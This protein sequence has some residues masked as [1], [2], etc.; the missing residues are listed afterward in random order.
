M[1]VISYT[2]LVIKENGKQIQKGMNFGIQKTYSV[3]LMSTQKNAPYNDH[4]L[5]E[6]VI[7]YEGHDVPS[8]LNPDKKLVDQS[9]LTPSGTPTENG[10][11]FQAALDYKEGI[12]EPSQVQVYR[13]LRKG[14][15]VDMG[16]YDLIDAYEK[17][18][19]ERKVFKFLLK[20]KIEL[21]EN[22]QE[23]LDLL[24]DRQIPGEVQKE[25][26]ERDR[27]KCVKCG[28]TENLH[29]D[30]ILPFSKGGS[31]KVAKNI[32]LLCARHNLKKGAKFV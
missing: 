19:L 7:E 4:I 2:Q 6:G 18:D 29:F 28:S 12:K 26:Y 25:V 13:K 27:G 21:N 15:W 3:V 11:F 10:K 8:N 17:Q 5:E 22:D 24:H 9:L 32:Q 1:K 20:P 30:H 16:F 14:I 31:S 23:Y